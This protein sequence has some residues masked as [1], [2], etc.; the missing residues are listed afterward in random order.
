[1]TFNPL[2]L[3]KFVPPSARR[4]L[5]ITD[6]P[7]PLRDIAARRN[8]KLELTAASPGALPVGET[9]DCVVVWTPVDN[10][11]RFSGILATMPERCQVLAA[12]QAV[13]P[14]LS[15]ALAAAG[16]AT[17]EVE[18]VLRAWR[19]TAQPRQIMLHC[20]IPPQSSEDAE[21]RIHRPNG[22]LRTIP[23]L[24]PV[25][26]L[27]SFSP[28]LGL[29]GEGRI[30]VMHRS[31]P[32]RDRNVAFLKR[33]IEHGYLILL[34]LDDDPEHFPAYFADG[35]FSLRCLHAI[36]V[37]TDAIAEKLRDR[38]PEIAVFGN[39]TPVLPPRRARGE[40]PVKLFFGAYNREED[41]AEILGPLNRLLGFLG[42]RVEMHVVH[43]L[44][45][46]DHLETKSKTFTPKCSYEEFQHHL[47]AAD[48]AFLPLRD[49]SFN[50][51]KSDLKFIECAAN[52]VA[53]LA[54]P[55]VYGSSV[56]DGGSGVLYRTPEEFAVGLQRLIQDPDLRAGLVDNAYAHVAGSRMLADH[57]EA[58]HAWYLDL[59]DRAEELRAAHRA[60]APELY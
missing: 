13:G 25:T 8:P 40:G 16:C 9:F 45:F 52:G 28:S 37:S 34:D 23:G 50:R 53:V 14:T 17:F 6:R 54:S 39:Q 59:L 11:D 24:R 7:T 58:R 4:V 32:M 22:F 44:A 42:D 36:Q 10:I 49:T 2:D 35:A 56:V 15:D 55:T 12:P 26:E 46:F 31:I 30:V 19:S 29:P 3:I 27:E 57:Y 21:V 1:M 5:E 38:V 48:I 33:A 43:D 41:S 47:S 20:S 18:P 51:C 60:R